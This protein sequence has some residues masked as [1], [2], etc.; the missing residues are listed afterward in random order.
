MKNYYTLLNV[1]KNANL[2][3]I[4]KSYHKLALKYHPDRNKGQF[5]NKF[6]EI[7]EAYETLS[8]PQKK[9]EYDTSLHFEDNM[10]N[11]NRNNNN[12]IH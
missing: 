10:F 11:L 6:K 2:N 1:D 4:K 12:N 7:T 5:E 3:E 8:D 9:K